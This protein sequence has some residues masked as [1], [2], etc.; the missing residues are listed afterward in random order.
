MPPELKETSEGG[1]AITNTAK[2]IKR[3]IFEKENV[4]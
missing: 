2:S 1:L 4:R 3:K